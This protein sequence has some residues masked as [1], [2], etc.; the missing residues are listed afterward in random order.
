MTQPTPSAGPGQLPMV[1]KGFN[2]IV[3]F[4]GRLVRIVRSG[5]AVRHTFGEGE[6][7]IP[8]P[9]ITSLGWK[10][11]GHLFNGYIFFGVDGRG[12]KRT[13]LGGPA[14]FGAALD[15]NT[16]MVNRSQEAAFLALRAA[17]EAERPDLASR[18]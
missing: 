4:D 11:P 1:V 13:A 16:V 17:I 2:G 6:K 10:K 18:P 14:A 12:Q 5:L 3:V 7:H 15:E 8:L 9:S